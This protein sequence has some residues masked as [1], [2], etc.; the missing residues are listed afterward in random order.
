VLTPRDTA[1]LE[2]VPSDLPKFELE[3]FNLVVYEGMVSRRT[4]VCSK[5]SNAT[6]FVPP[7]LG[8]ELQPQV[9]VA[10]AL[11]MA[12]LDEEKSRRFSSDSNAFFGRL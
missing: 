9:G 3:V 4:S 5:S 7:H 10:V 8:H 6:E 11:A 2:T 1:P 12:S